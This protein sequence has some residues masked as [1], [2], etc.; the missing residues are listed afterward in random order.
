MLFIYLFVR[1]V[2]YIIIIFIYYL[3]YYI[4]IPSLLRIRVRS[5]LAVVMP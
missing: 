3:L 2:Y 5:D 1:I 4:Y